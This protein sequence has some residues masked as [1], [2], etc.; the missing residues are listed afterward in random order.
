[1]PVLFSNME[2]KDPPTMPNVLPEPI[3]GSLFLLLSR[4]FLVM[5]GT[6]IIYLSVRIFV[7]ELNPQWING[8]TLDII[9]FIFLIFSYIVQIF[10]IYTVLLHWLNKRYYIES[11]HLIIKR[12]IFT[13]T[14]RV[15]DL[16]DLRSVVVTQGIVGKIFHF[17]TITLE[18]TSPGLSEEPNLTEIPHPHQ[19]EKQIKKFI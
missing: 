4:I 11:N 15:Y 3:R 8:I 2:I 5:A 9:F 6:D 10:L 12:G 7:F 19:L 13:I 14:E 16:K 18:I 1:M 17:G